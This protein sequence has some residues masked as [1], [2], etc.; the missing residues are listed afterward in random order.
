VIVLFKINTGLPKTGRLFF[1][2]TLALSKREGIT[3]HPSPVRT[4]SSGRAS[5]KGEGVAPHPSPLLKERVLRRLKRRGE[6]INCIGLKLL[7]TK[8]SKK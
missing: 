1:N 3:P 5:P 7:I 2:L 8:K 4:D 6:R